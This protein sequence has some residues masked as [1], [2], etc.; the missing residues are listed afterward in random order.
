MKVFLNLSMNSE[1]K[2]IED[3][4]WSLIK[5]SRSEKV[6]KTVIRRKL[7]RQ[8]YKL[9][10]IESAINQVWEKRKG[11]KKE[12]SRNLPKFVPTTFYLTENDRV[13]LTDDAYCALQ[14]LHYYQMLSPI[15]RILLLEQIENAPSRIHFAKLIDILD[16]ILEGRYGF[17]NIR[18][19]M[20]VAFGDKS[21]FM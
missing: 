1:I 19:I 16:T 9:S 20:S 3:K 12:T 10:D 6:S 15:D 5:E 2:K 18:V 4:I 14:R 13:K 17:D 8:G 7:S 11:T 21:L